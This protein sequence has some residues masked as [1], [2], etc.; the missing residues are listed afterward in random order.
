MV[1]I[2]LTPLR[3]KIGDD[4]T[5]D[6]VYIDRLFT[7]SFCQVIRSTNA[8]CERYETADSSLYKHDTIKITLQ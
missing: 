1:I 5:F 3:S 6:I 8:L 4:P 7:I 2:P